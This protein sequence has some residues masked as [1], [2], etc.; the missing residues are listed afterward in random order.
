MR[1]PNVMAGY[2][3]RPEDTAAALDAE[4]WLHTGDIGAIDAQGFLT[5]TDRKKDLLITSQGEN[6]APQPIEGALS[7]GA[8]DRR[9]LSDWRP[10]SLSDRAVGA[11]P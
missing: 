5:I 11:R 4:G 3:N 1:G 9:G 8:A 7:P 2:Y 10:A 6:I